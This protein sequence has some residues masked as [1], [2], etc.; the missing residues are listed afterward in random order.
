MRPE[1]NA[2]V[3]DRVGESVRGGLMNRKLVSL[4]AGSFVLVSA[5]ALAQDPFSKK[6]SS[7]TN[8]GPLGFAAKAEAKSLSV[9]SLVA[10][11][12][13]EKAGIKAGDTV[14]GVDGKAFSG[15]PEPAIAIVVACE[16]AELAAKKDAVVT[17]TVNGKDAGSQTFS[18]V[19]DT[20]LN[21]K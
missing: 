9:A 18:V 1:S 6:E 7:E 20:W 15:T 2:V 19:E 4:A 5:V 11:G 17:L 12:P 3:A 13:A 14:T 8:V 21:E 16:A 10:G